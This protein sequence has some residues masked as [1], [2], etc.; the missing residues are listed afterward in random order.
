MHAGLLDPLSLRLRPQTMSRLPGVHT[1]RSMRSRLQAGPHGLPDMDGS[2]HLT[3][4][5]S[6][7][8]VGAL[9]LKDAAVLLLEPAGAP[10][11][12]MI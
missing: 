3:I 11:A 9:S 1:K 8:H 2:T 12:S 5:A 4:C 7:S 6:S 10:C